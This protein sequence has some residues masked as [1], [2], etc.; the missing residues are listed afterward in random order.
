MWSGAGGEAV[1]SYP[2]N[3][4][5]GLIPPSIGRHAE[6]FASG[7]SEGACRYPR[8]PTDSGAIS[9]HSCPQERN[10]S[11]LAAEAL[12]SAAQI[13]ASAAMK[14]AKS[15]GDPIFACAPNLAKF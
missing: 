6:P 3:A 7:P 12:T 10:H 11:T 15:C 8:L 2:P 1:L 13:G 4:V 14:A 9:R 5:N